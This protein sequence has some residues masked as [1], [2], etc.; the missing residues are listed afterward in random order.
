MTVDLSASCDFCLWEF[1][2]PA[3]TAV[4]GL[5]RREEE[6]RLGELLRH[7]REV[8]DHVTEPSSNVRWRSPRPLKEGNSLF[9]VYKKST[10]SAAP[11][12]LGDSLEA[13]GKEKC[14][15]Q[16]DKSKNSIKE[17]IEEDCPPSRREGSSLF[18]F[19]DGQRQYGFMALARQIAQNGENDVSECVGDSGF[20]SCGPCGPVVLDSEIEFHILERNNYELG[21]SG[22][23]YDFMTQASA[24][25]LLKR[26]PLGTFLIR[27]SSHPKFLYALSMKSD[28][29]ATSVRVS[30]S[31]GCFGFDGEDE[32]AEPGRKFDSVVAL[33]DYYASEQRL[34]GKSL[35]MQG[36]FDRK[37]VNIV[38]VHPLRMS[39]SRLAHLS[40]IK[41]NQCL[42]TEHL[43][44]M[45]IRQL[46][47]LS[48]K[49]ISILREYPYRL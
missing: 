5:S 6:E 2:L 41:I 3:H 49:E 33:V 29:G 48:E 12:G 20:S 37:P 28:Q 1:Q 34:Y 25:R 7:L 44:E 36:K 39:V 10:F 8:L 31:Q 43:Y 24:M 17:T 42:S 11:I 13:I 47:I 15:L 35:T 14:Q 45:S 9:D 18:T 40:R 27:N 46:P 16:E 21:L 38:F 30:Y 26:A 23:Y 4:L 19:K 22:Y 32:R